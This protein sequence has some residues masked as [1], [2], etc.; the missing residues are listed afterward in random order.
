MNERFAESIRGNG[1][2]RRGGGRSQ[3]DFAQSALWSNLFL[4]I[5]TGG[6]T[7]YETIEGCTV[8][9]NRGFNYFL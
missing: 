5:V 9:K 1:E 7:V 4:Y 6:T 2:R 8:K 3:V